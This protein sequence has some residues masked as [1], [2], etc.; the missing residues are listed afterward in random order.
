LIIIRIENILNSAGTRELE[1]AFTGYS[2]GVIE[3]LGGFC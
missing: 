3:T 1:N 2:D